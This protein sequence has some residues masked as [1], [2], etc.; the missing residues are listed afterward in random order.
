MAPPLIR[1]LPENLETLA[2]IALDLRW[3]WSHSAD[4]L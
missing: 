3:T 1:P 2:E 4:Q